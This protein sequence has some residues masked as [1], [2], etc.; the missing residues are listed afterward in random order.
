MNAIN[1]WYELYE[2]VFIIWNR[3]RIDNLAGTDIISLYCKKKIRIKLLS[4]FIIIFD[5]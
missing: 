5:K 1:L 2:F 3:M 4:N